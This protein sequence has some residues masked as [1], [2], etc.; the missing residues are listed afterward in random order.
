MSL[1]PERSAVYERGEPKKVVRRNGGAVDP[2]RKH[3]NNESGKFDE[4]VDLQNQQQNKSPSEA[5]TIIPV[6]STETF[7]S[8]GLDHLFK[9]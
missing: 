5:K 2:L 7:L 8:R 6:I 3:V 4:A 9:G 1:H